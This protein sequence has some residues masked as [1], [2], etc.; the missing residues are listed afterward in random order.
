MTL[1][2]YIFTLIIHSFK[3]VI[4]GCRWKPN[5]NYCLVYAFEE[6]FSFTSRVFLSF[7]QQIPT[8]EKFRIQQTRKPQITQLKKNFF[9][10]TFKQDF[11]PSSFPL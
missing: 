6:T 10:N 4:S 1:I 11:Y 3:V 2:M 7:P 8:Q 5:A 9:C